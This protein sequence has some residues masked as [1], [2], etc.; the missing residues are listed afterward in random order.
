MPLS[1]TFIEYHREYSVSTKK[2]K[3]FSEDNYVCSLW[4]YKTAC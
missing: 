2:R 4:Q 1:S 3:I